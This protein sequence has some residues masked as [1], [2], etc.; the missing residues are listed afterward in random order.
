MVSLRQ[1]DMNLLCQLWSLNENIQVNSPIT[2][3]SWMLVQVF[4]YFFV[5]FFVFRLHFLN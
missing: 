3:E 1:I 2:S 4:N 5:L